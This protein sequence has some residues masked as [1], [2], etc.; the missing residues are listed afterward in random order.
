MLEDDKPVK[1][2]TTHSY[3]SHDQKLLPAYDGSL[4][5]RKV[6]KSSKT[7]RVNKDKGRSAARR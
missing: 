2:P 5:S 6:V 4:G 3:I 7:G 1:L